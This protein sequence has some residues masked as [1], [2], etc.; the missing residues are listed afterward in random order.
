MGGVEASGEG[1]AVGAGASVG[2]SVGMSVTVGVGLGDSRLGV[3]A[4]VRVRLASQPT[5][6][7]AAPT[8]NDSARV[9]VV[10]PHQGSRILFTGRGMFGVN[11]RSCLRL[12]LVLEKC[13]GGADAFGVSAM[14]RK[15][16]PKAVKGL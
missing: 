7:I 5:R 10:P 3:G 15:Y 11:F 16:I 6:K 1:S 12:I 4:A 2:D 8:A 14:R 9:R 13:T